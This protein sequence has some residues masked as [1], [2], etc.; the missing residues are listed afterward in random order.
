M[1]SVYTISNWVEDETLGMVDSDARP[2]FSKLNTL[3]HRMTGFLEDQSKNLFGGDSTSEVK[4]Q[5]NP[6]EVNSISAQLKRRH[7]LVYR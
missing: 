3:R 7:S 4:S 2:T 6:Q 1:A 5:V